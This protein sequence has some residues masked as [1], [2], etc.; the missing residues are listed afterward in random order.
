M[1][2]L[3]VCVVALGLV[4]WLS[5]TTA[6]ADKSD[7]ALLNGPGGDTSVQCGATKPEL[8][9]GV[10]TFKPTAFVIHITMSNRAAVDALIHVDYQD[11]A[12]EY[13]IPAGTTVQISLA[14]G[15]SPGSDQ[16]I[17]VKQAG[18]AVLQGQISLITDD[19]KPHPN[20]PN[21]ALVHPGNYCTTC[22]PGGGPGC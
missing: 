4:G 17:T 3:A 22:P 10:L 16:I 7:F 11:D 1:R 5:V 12:V 8:K 13:A 20:L 18:G 19:G 2:K 14:G 9:L 15:G 6:A 21:Q